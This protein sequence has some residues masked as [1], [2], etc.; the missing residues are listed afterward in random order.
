MPSPLP[1]PI[2]AGEGP[3]LSGWYFDPAEAAGREARDD[4]DGNVRPA[5]L[6]LPPLAEERKGAVRPLGELGRALSRAGH[7][8]LFFDY[9]GTGDSPGDFQDADWTRWSADLDDAIHALRARAERSAVHNGDF[10]KAGVVL[11]CVR[12]SARLALERAARDDGLVSGLVFWEPLPDTSAWL[13]EIRRRSRFRLGAARSGLPERDVDGYTFSEAL[14]R[15]L[16]SAPA[17]DLRPP[18][19]MPARIVAV[20]PG[21]RVAPGVRRLAES[22][23]VPLGTVDQPPFWL[24]NDVARSDELVA[25][26]LECIRSFAR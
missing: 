17:E 24:E 14:W 25:A 6:M 13:A 22:W 7:P 3:P 9:F 18:A 16:D 10:E 21:G 2:A 5:V 1:Q 4:K 15:A 23:D 12:A 11:V 19:G 26:T 8:A 20:A